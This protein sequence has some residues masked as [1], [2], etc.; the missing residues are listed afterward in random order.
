MGWVCLCEY[1]CVYLGDLMTKRFINNRHTNA[2]R[3]FLHS[4]TLPSSFRYYYL[5]HNTQQL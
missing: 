5:P 2:H 3:F 4:N 1:L